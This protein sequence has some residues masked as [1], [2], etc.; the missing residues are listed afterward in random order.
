MA[1]QRL[2]LVTDR[3]LA[4]PAFTTYA[5]PVRGISA[6][7]VGNELYPGPWREVASRLGGI[8]RQPDVTVPLQVLVLIADSVSSL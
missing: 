8:V 2:M 7:A 3:M 4:P 5:E 1:L 6:R